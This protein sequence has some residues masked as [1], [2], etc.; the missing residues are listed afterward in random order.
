LG[1]L[2]TQDITSP[3]LPELQIIDEALFNAAQEITEQRK[4][5]NAAWRN[6]PR[7]NCSVCCAA[8]IST[9]PPAAAV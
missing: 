8:G 4:T 3:H 7:Q 1:Y 2:I 9:A 5:Q 6:I